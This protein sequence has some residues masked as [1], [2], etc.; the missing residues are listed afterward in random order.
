M[1]WRFFTGYWHRRR[2]ARGIHLSA[3]GRIRRGE[4]ASPMR[5]RRCR[6]RDASAA[7]RDEHR[8][9]V[10]L[11]ADGTRFAVLDSEIGPV[12]ADL[13]REQ[14]VIDADLAPE[15][16]PDINTRLFS[17]EQNRQL[18]FVTVRRGKQT[19]F[20]PG[21]TAFGDVTDLLVRRFAKGE[22]RFL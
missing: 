19:D 7:D 3:N 5:I 11:I 21:A 15:I 8:G 1:I 22:N 14:R 20:R 4:L 18:A 13:E 16:R 6:S 12:I 2:S 10:R 9:I 17:V